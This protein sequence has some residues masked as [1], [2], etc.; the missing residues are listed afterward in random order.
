M[1]MPFGAK[2]MVKTILLI[3]EEKY[4]AD[5]ENIK[6][7]ETWVNGDTIITCRPCAIFS[8]GSDFPSHLNKLRRGKFGSVEKVTKTGEKKSNYHVL[9]AVKDHSTSDLHIFCCLKEKNMEEN[10]KCFEKED[11]AAGRITIR[12]VIKTIKRGGSAGDFQASQN[13]LHLESLHQNITVSTKNNS[14]DAFFKIRGVVFE[15]VTE[16]TKNWFSETGPG[17]IEEISVT[18]D[19]VTIQRTRF[20]ALLTYFFHNG[21][22]YIILNK[23]FVM[24]AVEY[25]SEGTARSVVGH[26]METLG[27]TRFVMHIIKIIIIMYY[28][29]ALCKS[30]GPGFFSSVDNSYIVV[31]GRDRPISYFTLLMMEFMLLT[32]SG[33]EGEVL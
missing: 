1:A 20:T 5:T 11:E 17:Q 25:N 30:Y 4:K 29:Y 18:L 9:R 24:A 28:A 32:S 19:K 26:L 16:E 22:I 31:L 15:V 14:S 13:M 33:L 2:A 23:L 6:I 12:D 8:D 21:V 3:K 27:L 10:K 7:E